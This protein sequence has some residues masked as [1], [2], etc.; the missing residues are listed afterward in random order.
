MLGSVAV[1]PVTPNAGAYS[2]LDLPDYTM[3]LD[4]RGP[5]DFRT[6][7]FGEVLEN[8]VP[9]GLL[10]DAIVVIGVKTPSVKDSISTPIADRF[11]GAVFHATVIDQILRSALKGESPPRW[12]PDWAEIAWIGL[13]T[14]VGG[15]LSLVFRS[16]W[17]LA[18]AL[19]ALLGAIG[20]AGW[21]AMLHSLW[22]PITTPAFGA[23]VAATFGTSLALFLEYSERRV[24]R[25]LFSRH[26]SEEVL[27][28]LW[29]ERDQL[30]EGGRLKPQRVIATVLFTDL[31]DY[32]TIAEEM[33]PTDLMNWVNEYM[34]CIAPQVEAHG[35]IV[36]SYG[37]DALMAVFGA[38]VPH[39]R[40]EDIDEDAIRAVECALA[41]RRELKTLNADWTARKLPTVS[42]RVGIYT[43]PVVTGSIGSSQ[44]LEYTALGDTTNIAARL[45][46]LGK[47]LPPDEATDPCT[48]LIGDPTWQRLHGR[49]SA[50]LVGSRRLK[51]RAKE[52]LIHSILCATST[53]S[54][55]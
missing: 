50:T 37:G 5:Q 34:S 39:T 26:V 31:K 42:M 32:S 53:T 51:G 18:P 30:L 43:G 28:V 48:I 49:F 52:V 55:L 29:A 41:M 19:A 17:K 1:P 15:A 46:S 40:E 38:P 27:A 4:F 20:F 16:P 33:D 44:R 54:T 13:C 47:E 9:A 6:I 35:G 10:K 7:T 23:V 36:N 14:L 2:G 11:R 25:S 3:L 12:W 45:Q 21:T 24:M 22:I 8:R